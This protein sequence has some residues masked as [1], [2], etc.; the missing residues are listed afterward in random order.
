MP[1]SIILTAEE[2]D[3][4]QLLEVKEVLESIPGKYLE[5]QLKKGSK[6][7]FIPSSKSS[8]PLSESEFFSWMRDFRTGFDLGNEQILVFLTSQ[9]IAN[10]HFNGIDFPNKSI[11]V[12]LNNWEKL[13][14]GNHPIKYPIAFHVLIS[15]LIVIYFKEKAGAKAA[16]H[17]EDMGCILDFNRAKTKVDLKLLTAR[18]CPTC[19]DAFLNNLPDINLL[20][21]FR[22]GLE[23]IR[24]DIVEGEYYRKIKPK[25]IK[26]II[27]K[28]YSKKSGCRI[29]FENIGYLQLDVAHTVVYLYFLKKKQG[30]YLNER[31]KDFYF[32]AH[33]YEQLSGT[34]NNKLVA[35]LCGLRWVDGNFETANS[36]AISERISR[37]NRDISVLL[38]TFGLE[39]HYQILKR[40][41]N[42]HGIDHQLTVVD[43][44]GI[45][46]KVEPHLGTLRI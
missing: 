19:M 41:T 31:A 16:L 5:Y 40:D 23:K 4:A 11:F 12:D 6:G 28:D 17:Q 35:N 42:K 20:A 1:Y 36:N 30:F 38:G 18:I 24:H 45:L 13:L 34:N 44:T 7:P 10:N 9:P 33:L 27:Q 25:P 8:G 37:I 3:E 29:Y 15:L 2:Q 22:S 21:Y 43:E 26:V 14:V 46:K 39:K 32:F